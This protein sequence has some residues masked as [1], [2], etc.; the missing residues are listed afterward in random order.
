[1][2][3]FAIKPIQAIRG[4]QQFKELVILPD[5][6]DVSQINIEIEIGQLKIYED[7]LETKYKSSF[8]RII[9][10]MNQAANLQLLPK[11][12]WREVTPAKERIKEYEV[13]VGDLRVYLIKIPNGQLVILGGYKNQQFSDFKKFRSL[14]KQYL[15]FINSNK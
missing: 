7:S 8:N 11:T 9:S 14:K 6:I 13:K 2:P 1:M 4:Q 15:K 5:D 3:T 12:Q 10:I